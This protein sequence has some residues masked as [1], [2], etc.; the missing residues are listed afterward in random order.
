MLVIG[1]DSGYIEKYGLSTLDFPW[2]Q[3][4]F[5]VYS[6]RPNTDTFLIKMVHIHIQHQHP[7]KILSQ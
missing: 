7:L 1:L 4:I 3:A 2:A 5:T 6:S